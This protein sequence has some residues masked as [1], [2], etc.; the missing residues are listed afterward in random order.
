MSWLM[1]RLVESFQED[2]MLERNMPLACQAKLIVNYPATARSKH[3]ET[4]RGIRRIGEI[5][6]GCGLRVG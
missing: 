2:L 1:N 3:L 6:V 5:E 4:R